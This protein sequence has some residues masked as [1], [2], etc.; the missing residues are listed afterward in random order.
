M[1]R[2][3]EPGR[4]RSPRRSGK[5]SDRGRGAA[6]RAQYGR[7]FLSS[8]ANENDATYFLTFHVHAVEQAPEEFWEYVERKE[9]EYRELEVRVGGDGGFNHRQHAVLSRAL[10]DPGAVFTIESHRSSHDIAYAT[11]RSDLVDLAFRGYLV[12][13]REGRSFAFFPAPGKVYGSNG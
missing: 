13:V 12:Q 9:R 1:L 8:E 6:S 11:A 4:R 5:E 3:P 2:G 10:R 7:A